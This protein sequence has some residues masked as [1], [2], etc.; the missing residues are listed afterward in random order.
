MDWH[1]KQK[2]DADLRRAARHAPIPKPPP[3]VKPALVAALAD[4]GRGKRHVGIKKG[5]IINRIIAKHKKPAPQLVEKHWSM[6]FDGTYRAVAGDPKKPFSGA[7]NY[8]AWLLAK[9]WERLGS[10]AHS[11]VYAKPDSDKVIKVTSSLDNWIDYV[12]WAAKAGYA[13][14]LAPRVYSWKRHQIENGSFAVAIV[15]KMERGGYSCNYKDD[16]ALLYGLTSY[17]RN[18]N[19]IAQCV[20]EDIQPGSVNFFK[21]LSALQYDGDVGG[22]NIMYRKDGSLCLTDPCAGRIKTTVKRLRSGDL[23]PS[24]YGYFNDYVETNRPTKWPVQREEI[25]LGY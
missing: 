25:L 14:N 13:G 23:S 20:M 21:Q 12:Q 8:G 19:L 18:G 4:W 11:I 1:Q 9:G 10:G 6:G 7:R 22:N 24:L 5:T 16:G 2:W 3:A 17:A 15:E